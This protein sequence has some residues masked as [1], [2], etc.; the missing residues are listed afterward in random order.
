[1]RSPRHDPLRLDVAAFASDGGLLDGRWPGASLERLADLQVPP[2]DQGPADVAWQVQG[3]RK[4]RPGSEAELWL[5]LSARATV[6]LTC[7]RCL[8]PLSVD[9]A[10]QRRLRFVHGEA[11]AAALDADSDDDVL[12]LSRW[13]DLREL[14]EDEMLLGLPLVPRH[15]TCPQPLPVSIGLAG[16]DDAGPLDVAGG[17][18]TVLSLHDEADQAVAAEAPGPGDDTDAPDTLPDGRPN[19]FAVL[20]VLKKGGGRGGSGS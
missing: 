3:E 18:G 20:K 14:V 10:L 15:D 13:L 5:T 1:M 7:Q 12:A 2:Q 16:E 6:W 11:Q 17:E 4:L 9:L 8:Q 19:P